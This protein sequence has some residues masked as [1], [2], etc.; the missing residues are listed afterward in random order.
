MSL[1][2]SWFTCHQYATFDL[3]QWFS[4]FLVSG[5]F[6]LL[7]SIEGLKEFLFMWLYLLLF[8]ILEI[9]TEKLLNVYFSKL[10]T[11]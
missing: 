7:K 11:C 1:G 10:I 2:Q 6:T 9:K 8:A 3:E 5:L 4:N